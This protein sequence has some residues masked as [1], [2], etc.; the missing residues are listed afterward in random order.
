MNVPED[1][2]E[3]GKTHLTG[4]YELTIERP[5]VELAKGERVR[6]SDNLKLTKFTVPFEPKGVLIA[7]VENESPA[8]A[9]GLQKGDVVLSVD[10]QPTISVS[11]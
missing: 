5:E 2:Y 7:G 10:N 3:Y 1:L 11:R 4:P 6:W 8:G 9:A